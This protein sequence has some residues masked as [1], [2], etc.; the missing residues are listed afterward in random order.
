METI[1]FALITFSSG[2]EVRPLQ[3]FQSQTACQTEQRE[4]LR[5]GI[6]ALCATEGYELTATRER[7]ACDIAKVW[8]TD[9]FVEFCA[10]LPRT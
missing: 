4:L 10:A 6:W 1:L 7:M 3:D 8:P 2:A 9:T 5:D